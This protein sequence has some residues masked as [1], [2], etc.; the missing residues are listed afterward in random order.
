MGDSHIRSNLKGKL[1]TETITNFATMGDS[2][3]AISGSTVTSAGAV[4][5]TTITGSTYAQAPYLIVG[6]NKYVFFT[7]ANTA[8]TVLADATALVGTPVKGSL[9]LG[10]GEIWYFPSDTTASL[11]T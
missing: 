11:M 9:S 10:A 4:S 1:G 3:T 5:G 7:N 8:A 2:S 6:T